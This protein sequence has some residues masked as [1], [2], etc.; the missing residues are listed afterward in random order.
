M[1]YGKTVLV[2]GGNTGIG[3]ETCLEFSR[4]GAVVAFTYLKGDTSLADLL[5]CGMGIQADI[6]KQKDVEKVVHLIKKRYGKLDVLVNNAGILQHSKMKKLKV[7]DWKKTFEVNVFGMFNLTKHL[8]P[9]MKRGKIV[10]I[11]SIRGV[12]GSN[13]DIDYSA[14]KAAVINFTQSLAKELAPRINVNC[15]S[16]GVT[17]TNLVN[18]YKKSVKRTIM[19]TLLKRIAEPDEI[20]KVIVFLASD[21]ASYITGQNII[22]DGG[23]CVN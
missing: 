18:A 6:T 2:T 16:P 5:P 23:Y 1:L 15:V 4:K 20:A 13:K 12:E 14:S 8:L 17:R 22:V 7:E 21:S 3:R 10:N 9:L 11:S 19:K